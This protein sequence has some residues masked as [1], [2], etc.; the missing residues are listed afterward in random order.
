M[1]KVCAGEIGTGERGPIEFRAR[2]V[3]E[4]EVGP[5]QLCTQEVRSR[6]VCALEI[7]LAQIEE[8]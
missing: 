3:D 1:R 6:Q 4:G 2:K 8:A 5:C 7:E